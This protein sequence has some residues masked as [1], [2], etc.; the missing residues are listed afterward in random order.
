M[1]SLFSKCLRHGW[2]LQF[3]YVHVIDID[4]NV[5]SDSGLGISCSASEHTCTA[6]PPKSNSLAYTVWTCLD[7]G[8]QS[9]P[10][11]QVELEARSSSPLPWPRRSVA[12]SC[13]WNIPESIFGKSNVLRSPKRVLFMCSAHLQFSKLC[14]KHTHLGLYGSDHETNCDLKVEDWLSCISVK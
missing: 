10:K 9:H 13:P 8:Q 12:S 3:L 5:H 7:Q 11:P 4:C 2:F 14:C 6:K 1:L